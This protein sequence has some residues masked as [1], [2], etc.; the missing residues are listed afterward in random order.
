MKQLGDILLDEGL[1]TEGQLMAALDEQAVRGE[2]LGRVLVEIGMLTE[3][4]LV[5]ALASQVGMQ[6]VDLSEYPVDRNAVVQ[7][8]A[9][10]AL[11]TLRYV[12]ANA[13]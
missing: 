7:A 10:F 1:V 5:Q 6:F 8:V 3:A 4:Q 11:D 13:G 2:S 9:D 12:S